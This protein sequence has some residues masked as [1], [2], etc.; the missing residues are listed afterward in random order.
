[1]DIEESLARVPAAPLGVAPGPASL[2][3]PGQDRNAGFRLLI[4]HM[5]GIVYVEFGEP[6]FRARHLSP[7]VSDVLGYPPERFT[8]D[9]F[10]TSIVHPEDLPQFQAREQPGS[11][12]RPPFSAEY[13]MRD[14]AGTWHWFLDEAIHVDPA[15]GNPGW[16]QGYS[17]TSPSRR[18]ASAI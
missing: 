13:R 9:G 18:I 6:G 8:E 14:V 3:V 11:S 17:P 16:W 1:M 15:D 4:E 10:W 12:D 5:P 7:R 2:V